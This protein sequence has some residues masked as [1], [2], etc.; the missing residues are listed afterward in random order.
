M[1]KLVLGIAVALFVVIGGV[2]TYVIV[3]NQSTNPT[4]TTPD[5]SPSL[6]APFAACDILTEDIAK[7]LLGDAI[8]H[9]D[10]ALGTVST[11]DIA[12]STCDYT[13]KVVADEADSSGLPKSDGLSL[14]VRVAKTAAGA[15]SN[16][17]AFNNPPPDAQMVK[18]FG[19][20]AFYAP[21]FHQLNIL[22]GGN[23]YVIIYYMDTVTNAS[24][25]TDKQLAKK[26]S[27]R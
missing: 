8:D 25:E 16:K 9:P 24:L 2:C 20:K 6:S 14:M 11:T 27:Y 22:K 5:N 15:A 7:S 13:T 19:D 4:P 12:I 1:N 3:N 18:N 17:Q 23:W 21:A 26:L 10:A